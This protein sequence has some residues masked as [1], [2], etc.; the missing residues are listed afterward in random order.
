MFS[1]NVA[2]EELVLRSLRALPLIKPFLTPGGWKEEKWVYWKVP[3]ALKFVRT[4]RMDSFLR[5]VISLSKISALNFIA[6]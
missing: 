6:L 3:V 1:S 5:K 2:F 4:S